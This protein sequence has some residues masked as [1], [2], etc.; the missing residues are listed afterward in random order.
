MLCVSTWINVDTGK[1]K[2]TNCKYHWPEG[3]FGRPVPRYWISVGQG[4]LMKEELGSVNSQQINS[5][6]KQPF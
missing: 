6:A 4:I 2:I 5:V 1:K 3:L